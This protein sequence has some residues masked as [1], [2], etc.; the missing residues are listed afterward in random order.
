MNIYPELVALKQ[1]RADIE[2]RITEAM[3]ARFLGKRVRVNHHN[4]SFT[5]VVRQVGWSGEFS[6]MVRNDA[7][8]KSSQRW[9]L[10][11]SRGL[12]DIELIDDHS[13]A[14]GGKV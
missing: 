14:E 13:H 12:P 1:E 4:G 11:S 2:K 10:C 6:V 8:G 7:T 5:G 9:P 3:K